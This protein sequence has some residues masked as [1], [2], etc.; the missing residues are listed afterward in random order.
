MNTYNYN[1]IIFI[2]C[3]SIQIGTHQLLPSSID[4]L[5]LEFKLEIE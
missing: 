2:D 1:F 3:Y 4:A 5:M